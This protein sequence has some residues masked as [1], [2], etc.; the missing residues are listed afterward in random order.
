V[1]GFIS[2]WFA[3][4]PYAAFFL[5]RAYRLFA[6]CCLGFFNHVEGSLILR[7]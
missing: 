4:K 1:D 5:K 3:M 6:L 2:P 7:F